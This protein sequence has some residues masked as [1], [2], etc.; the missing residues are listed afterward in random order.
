LTIEITESDSWEEYQKAWEN[1]AVNI[2]WVKEEKLL[3]LNKK[4]E[5]D[6]LKQYFQNPDN[7]FLVAKLPKSDEI[8]GC[9]SI[10]VR[11]NNARIGRWE[12]VIQDPHQNTAAK[13]L[14]L[15]NAIELLKERNIETLGT[16]LKYEVNDPNETLELLKL[17]ESFGFKD[18][19]PPA[20][21]L[22]QDVAK[23]K[24]STRPIDPIKIKTRSTYTISDFCK[25]AQLS[26][27][28]LKDDI[29]MHGWDAITS[30]YDTCMKFNKFLIDGNMGYS[31]EDFWLVATIDNT[32]AGYLMAYAPNRKDNLKLG[33]IGELG[34]LPEYR[35]KGVASVLI[36][37]ILQKF[38]DNDYTYSYV[39]TPATNFGAI[40][41]YEKNGFI[42]LHR[43]LF[44]SMKL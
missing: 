22:Y 40:K 8:I 29:E 12:P 10:L 14:L 36:N 31:P 32:P 26:F 44:L 9:L 42:Q 39:G 25:F 16:T 20:I 41:V 2:P 1:C 33:M 13:R 23:Y 34:V 18:R 4:E 35:G 28:T 38:K 15:E 21:Q 7:I 6:D 19:I 5:L 17:L 3:F 11:G 27:A 24:G 30:D 37:E 43:V